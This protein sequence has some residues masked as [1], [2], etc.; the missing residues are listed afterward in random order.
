MDRLYPLKSLDY[1]HLLYGIDEQVRPVLFHVQPA[2]PPILV[3]ES[4]KDRKAASQ[5]KSL[6]NS[7]PGHADKILEEAKRVLL[8]KGFKEDH[9]GLVSAKKKVGIA[10]DICQYSEDRRVDAIAISTVGRTRVEA[11]L[12]GETANKVLE[13][14]R[15]CPVWMIKGN[16][17][18]RN[19]IIALDSSENA[20]RAVDHVGFML[21]GT[22]VQLTLY[23]ACRHL[24]RYVSQSEI[25]DAPELE[26]L[27]LD[28]EGREM[29]PYLEKAR[30]ILM[31]AGIQEK[32]LTVQIGDGS[33]SPAADIL[34]AAKKKRMRHYRHG[35]QGTDRV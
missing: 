28:A 15:V 8:D 22:E 10:R 29:A 6:E 7:K 17:S 30:N 24:R 13:A 26:K 2:L 5:V 25:E 18:K 31:K 11:F 14:S 1:I 16:V 21:S 35:P 4:R 12:L 23:H 33:R 9:I 32:Q 19:V 20:L 34:H 3:E 27:I